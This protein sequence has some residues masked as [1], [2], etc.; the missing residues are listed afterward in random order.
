MNTHSFF[1]L[2]LAFGLPL[3][4]CEPSD[5]PSTGA[6]DSSTAADA[7][8]DGGL[9]VQPTDDAAAVDSGTTPP[10]VDA[11]SATVPDASPLPLDAGSAP[12]DAGAA[13]GTYIADLTAGQNNPASPALGK[14]TCVASP[15]ALPA[16]VR[17]VCT[18]VYNGFATPVVKAAIG[19]KSAVG[20]NAINAT[21]TCPATASP[22]VCP[23]GDLP[24]SLLDTGSQI[25]VGVSAS[26]IPGFDIYGFLHT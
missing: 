22:I 14:V 8:S 9:W 1:P 26:N 17:V 4:A 21:I 20:F 12:V 5:A 16:N 6:V 24:L 25:R 10:S 13:P 2:V 11:G 23:A 7:S 19:Q 18:I 15:A 3:V